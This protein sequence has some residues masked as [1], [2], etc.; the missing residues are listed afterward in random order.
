MP[1]SACSE[2]HGNVLRVMDTQTVDYRH[3]ILISSGPARWTARCGLSA[4][5]AGS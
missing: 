2:G 3:H 4:R 1:L 5:V